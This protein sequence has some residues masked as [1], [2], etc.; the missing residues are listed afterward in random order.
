MHAEWYLSFF[1]WRLFVVGCM[2]NTVSLNSILLTFSLFLPWIRCKVEQKCK[3]TLIIRK[4]CNLRNNYNWKQNHAL[5]L[6]K[7]YYKNYYYH[8]YYYHHQHH[9]FFLLSLLLLNLLL[10]FHFINVFIFI[11]LQNNFK[12]RRFAQINVSVYL[13]KSLMIIC[14]TKSKHN[15]FI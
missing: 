11:S 3:R 13:Q 12:K 15:S 6:F 1:S 5:F 9:H 10:H 4:K 7:Y 2:K 8:Y 14:K